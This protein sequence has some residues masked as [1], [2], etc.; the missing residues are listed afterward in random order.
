[1]NVQNKPKGLEYYESFKNKNSKLDI[2]P[3]IIPEGL[4]LHELEFYP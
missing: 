3:T 2:C 1:M 4:G